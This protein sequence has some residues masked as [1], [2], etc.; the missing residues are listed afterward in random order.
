L[1]FNIFFDIKGAGG[2]AVNVPNKYNP[3]DAVDITD[4]LG[5]L[6]NNLPTMGGLLEVI[7]VRIQHVPDEH[8]HKAPNLSY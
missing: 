6:S 3:I 7:G 2:T 5:Q 4:V 1:K 8:P